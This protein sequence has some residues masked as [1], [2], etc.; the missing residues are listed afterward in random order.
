MEI[1][2]TPIRFADML[3]AM[4]IFQVLFRWPLITNT[5]VLGYTVSMLR[6]TIFCF[7]AKI[8]QKDYEMQ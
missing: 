2:S 7:L 3:A 4:G 6:K 8:S 1:P 5:G